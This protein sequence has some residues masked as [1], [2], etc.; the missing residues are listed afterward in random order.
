MDESFAQQGSETEQQR[1]SVPGTR[2]LH[3]LESW[4]AQLLQI[5]QLT[6][7]EQ[8]DAGIH[9]GLLSE[10]EQEQAGIRR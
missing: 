4:M 10:D 7:H 5:A 1:G 2:I 3:R 9:F 6:E 8:T